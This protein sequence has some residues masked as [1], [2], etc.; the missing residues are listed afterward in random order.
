M[1]TKGRVEYDIGCF[2]SHA[3]QRFQVL[4]GVG[5][6]AVMAVQKQGAGGHD[7]VGFAVE[8]PQGSDA[9][10]EF[11][12][13]ELQ[14]GARC[15]GFGVKF[16]GGFVDTCICGLGGQHD[17]DQQLESRAVLQLGLWLRVA[18][19]QAAEKRIPFGFVH[20]CCVSSGDHGLTVVMARFLMVASFVP[21]CSEAGAIL[22]A[23]ARVPDRVV[24]PAMYG[25]PGAV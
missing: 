9:V 16:A 25:S 6:L 2:S 7:I 20:R 10:L 18:I 24:V 14:N 17:G 11:V 3:R 12:H 5:H 23:G 19:A 4:P 1:L 8:Q 13:A 22:T 15:V 21:R